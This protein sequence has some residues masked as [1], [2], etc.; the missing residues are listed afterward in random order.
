M[1][2]WAWLDTISLILTLV[3]LFL[4]TA[5]APYVD[6]H[7]LEPSQA[8][9]PLLSRIHRLEVRLEEPLKKWTTED[10]QSFKESPEIPVTINWIWL[11]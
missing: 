7:R 5:T 1:V 4:A 8:L 10:A 6:P 9:R 3:V 2:D 11:L